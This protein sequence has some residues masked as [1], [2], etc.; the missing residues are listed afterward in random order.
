[1]VGT[2]TTN[3]TDND[4]ILESKEIKVF[5]ILKTRKNYLRIPFFKAGAQDLLAITFHK[6]ES[7]SNRRRKVNTGPCYI[8]PIDPYR[9]MWLRFRKKYHAIAQSAFINLPAGAGIRWMTRVL[10]NPI[11]GNISVT[12]YVMSLM[13]LSEAKGYTVFLIGGT[14]RGSEKLFFNFK[15][16]FPHLII[17]GRHHGE[18]VAQESELVRQALK[19]MSP[20]IILMDL[21]YSEGLDWMDKHKEAFGNS[22]TIN[23]PNEFDILAGSQPPHPKFL[24]KKHLIWFWQIC[25][26]PLR[27]YRLFLIFVWVWIVLVNRLFQKRD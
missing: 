17:I 21:G 25:K 12:N 19:K 23:M 3:K 1:M 5:S 10:R 15:H 2:Y 26:N 20:N 8:L 9:M 6:L 11:P 14:K 22:I 13:R 4:P 18:I 16:S 27:W 7:I 24:K